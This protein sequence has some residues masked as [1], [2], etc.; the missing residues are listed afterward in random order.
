MLYETAARAREILALNVEDRDLAERSARIVGKGGGAAEVFWATATARLSYRRA[1][2]LLQHHTG[3]TLHQLR[4]SALT[5]LAE[6]GVDVTLLKAKSRHKRLRRLEVYVH[7]TRAA[8]RQ[9]TADHD[10]VH[11]GR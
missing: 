7:P 2:E 10:R 6:V 9:L 4:H 5:H 1:E 11:R 3:R 8:V